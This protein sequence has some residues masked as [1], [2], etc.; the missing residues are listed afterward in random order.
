MQ[1]FALATGYNVVA[2]DA[3]LLERARRLVG[4]LQPEPAASAA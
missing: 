3:K 4:R 1:N 2:I